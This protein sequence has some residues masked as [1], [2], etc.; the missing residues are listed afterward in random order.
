MNPDETVPFVK[1]LKDGFHPV[2]C[3]KD[4]M[5]EH[6]DK[7]G[8]NKFQYKMQDVSNSSIVHYSDIVP[9]ED[10]EKMTPS[11]CFEFCRGIPDMGFFGISNGRDCYCENYYK[12]M[13]SDSSNCDSV[14]EG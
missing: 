10:R 11:V 4:A 8:D 14:C 13:A 3:V 9:K 2:D 5:Y 7:F 6:G 1:V 12:K